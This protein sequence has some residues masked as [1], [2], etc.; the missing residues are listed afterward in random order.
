MLM[1]GRKTSWIVVVLLVFLL[2]GW[3]MFHLFPGNNVITFKNLSGRNLDTVSIAV[4]SENLY[5]VRYTGIQNKEEV[6]FIIPAGIPKSNHHDVTTN[7]TVSYSGG[8]TVRG[9]HHD[10]LFM[11]SPF[12]GTITLDGNMQLN[13]KQKGSMFRLFP[14]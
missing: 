6:E 10:D 5:V 7:V 8:S 11:P 3:A 14:T 1:H 12:S 13:W 9:M 4:F 2:T